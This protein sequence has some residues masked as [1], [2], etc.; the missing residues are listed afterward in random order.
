[1]KIK[2]EK[3]QKQNGENNLTTTNTFNYQLLREGMNMRKEIKRFALMILAVLMLMENAVPVLAAT[4]KYGEDKPLKTVTK[5][6]FIVS[7]HGTSHKHWY[8]DASNGVRYF[9][10]DSCRDGIQHRQTIH[11]SLRLTE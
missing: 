6:Y 2:R 11:R 1:M 9:L 4:S 7:D 8:I 5:S 10:Y 3:F